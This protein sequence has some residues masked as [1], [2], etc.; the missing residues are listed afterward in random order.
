MS[1]KFRLG[2]PFENFLEVGPADVDSVLEGL[3]FVCGNGLIHDD[4]TGNVVK[5]KVDP[6]LVKYL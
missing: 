3:V 6:C 2:N 4:N 5:V 1:S